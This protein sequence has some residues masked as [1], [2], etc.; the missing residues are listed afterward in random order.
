MGSLLVE[1]ADELIEARLLL[2]EVPGGGLGG[3]LLERQM[4]AL[5]PAV[6]LRMAGLDALDADTQA[7]PPDRELGQSEE[8]VGTGKGAPVIGANRSGQPEVLKSALKDGKGV[9]RQGAREPLTADE[10][11]APDGGGGGG[12]REGATG[13]GEHAPFG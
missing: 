1:G 6:L 3:F 5:M 7:Q 12:E 4:H 9:H 13:E 8:R 10:V 2:Q 11:T